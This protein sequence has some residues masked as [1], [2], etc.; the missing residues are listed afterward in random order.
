M[1]MKARMAK[2]AARIR[3]L[4][5][6]GCAILLGIRAVALHPRLYSF[7]RIRGLGFGTRISPK[8]LGNDKV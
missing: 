5:G 8:S 2:T 1:M 7:A 3:G 4:D 6:V